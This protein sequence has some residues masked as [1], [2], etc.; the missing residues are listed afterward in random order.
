MEDRGLRPGLLHHRHID[1]R[2]G[3]GQREV[4]VQVLGRALVAEGHDRPGRF[5][6]RDADD[7]AGL[8]PERIA[9]L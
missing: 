7:A 6:Q 5:A 1:P 9:H 3:A 4:H 2:A 8:G